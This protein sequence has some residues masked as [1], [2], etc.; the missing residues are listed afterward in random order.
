MMCSSV[1]GYLFNGTA[2][3]RNLKDLV[4]LPPNVWTYFDLKY[5]AHTLLPPLNRTLDRL[6]FSPGPSMGLDLPKGLEEDLVVDAGELS[7]RVHS[8]NGILTPRFD[9]RSRGSPTPALLQNT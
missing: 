6:H 8:S 3:A 2:L 4:L 1:L 5:V 7:A 9:Q